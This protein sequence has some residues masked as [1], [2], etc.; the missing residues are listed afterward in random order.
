M[1]PVLTHHHLQ[2]VDTLLS[3]AANDTNPE[4]VKFL[5]QLEQVRVK[6]GVAKPLYLFNQSD[7]TWAQDFFEPGYA[8][9]PGPERTISIRVMIRSAQSTRT[10]GRQ[11]FEMLRGPG[12]GGFQPAPGFGHREINSGGNIETIPPYTSKK[13][14]QYK[15]GRIITG[16]HFAEMP[17]DKMLN[18]MRGQK[19]QDPLILETGWLAIG[20]VDEFVQ[21]VPFNNSLSWTISIADTKSA[22]QLLRDAQGAGS[23][24][25]RAISYNASSSSDGGS[26]APL[27]NLNV[28]ID[29]VL[30]DKTLMEMNE[31]AQKHIDANLDT[32]L[33][34]IDLSRDDVLRIP[35]LFKNTGFSS[36]SNGTNPGFPG[37]GGDGDDG[38]PDHISVL[39]PG[40][41]Q[42]AAFNPAAINGIVLGHQTYASPNP[43]GPIVSGEDV[44]AKEVQRQYARAGMTV[45]FVDDFLSHHVGGGEIHCGSNTLRETDAVWWG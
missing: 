41:H 18:F 23:G 33:A 15:A 14:V 38:L 27:D 43:F 26:F 12:I 19:L 39:P 9:M 5:K 1:A 40:E 29:Q 31:Y 30:A 25:A 17:S 37:V 35:S 36:S 21:F 24:K 34:E 22:V 4:Q 11:V 44:F 28:T 20:H 6:A 10:A 45:V 16:K 42:L 8:S 2:K 32:L 13:D 3:I 7:D